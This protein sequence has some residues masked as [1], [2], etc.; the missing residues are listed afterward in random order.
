MQL[1]KYARIAAGALFASV[2]AG[3]SAQAQTVTFRVAH[4]ASSKHP[5]HK[6]VEFY[7]EILEKKTAGKVKV[8]IFGDRKLGG[9]KD[10][11]LG[12]KA[13]TIDSAFVSSVL[14]A[15]VVRK[16]AFDALQ[17]PFVV[18]NYDNLNKMFLSNTANKML[19]SLDDIGIKGLGLGE[20]GLRHFLA[21]TGPVTTIAGFKGL[22]TRIVPVPLHKA[23]WS[24]LGANPVGIAYGEVYTTMATNG[25][26]AV[27]FNA[28]SVLAENLYKPAK[29]LSLTG[30][31]FWPLVLIHN[32]AKF[33]KLPKDVQKAM[34][35]AGREATTLHVQYVKKDEAST[36]DTLKANGVKV[37]KFEELDK[38]RNT[39]APIV[40]Q[41]VKRNPLIAEYVAEARKLE[42][43]K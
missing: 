18:S 21:R 8:Q 27:E 7:S 13:G 12:V 39:V 37:Y 36:L 35:E 31:Y 15:L 25:I 10:I 4:G 14:F 29:H 34:M 42:G 5:L 20:A 43:G 19:A 40:D 9:D 28:S 16:S 22:K 30:H 3:A 24:A 41:W 1:N 32:K 23:I 33:E 11:L 38:V 26:D 6:Y 2:I 17:L